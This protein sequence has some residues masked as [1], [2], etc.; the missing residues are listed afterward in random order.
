[1]P[2]GSIEARAAQ[3]T[4]LARLSHE[5][6]TEERLGLL[7]QKAAAELAEASYDSDDASLV[8]VT[9]RDYERA[10]KI[11]AELVARIARATSLGQQAWQEARQASSFAVFSPHLEHIIALMREKA[12]SLGYEDHIYDPLL[13][14]FEPGMSTARLEEVFADLRDELV[15]IVEVLGSA[16][17]DAPAHHTPAPLERSYD[18]RPFAVGNGDLERALALVDAAEST[19]V[20]AENVGANEAAATRLAR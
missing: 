8:R 11:P 19:F 15:P 20:S 3:L 14:E 13:T 1:M 2:P 4:T 9:T 7:L 12:E 10:T 6:F 5:T 16:A 18:E 17:A